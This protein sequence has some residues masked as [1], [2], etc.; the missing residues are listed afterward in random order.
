M[1]ERAAWAAITHV[2]ELP[3]IARIGELG[4]DVTSRSDRENE[5]GRI[6]ALLSLDTE[7]Q[8]MEI[9]SNMTLPV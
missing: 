8:R 5:K 6:A 9:F 7:F 3:E 1:S 4:R 2:G